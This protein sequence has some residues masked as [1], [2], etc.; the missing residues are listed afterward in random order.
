MCDVYY[1]VKED[2]LKICSTCLLADGKNPVEQEKLM[3]QNKMYIFYKYPLA[4]ECAIF[5]PL[6]K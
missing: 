4:R 2:F 6:C 5:S 1:A 3:T